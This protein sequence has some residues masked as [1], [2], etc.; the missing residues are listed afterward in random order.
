[1]TTCE[2]GVTLR[3]WELISSP[4]LRRENMVHLY[5]L[6]GAIFLFLEIASYIYFLGRRK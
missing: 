3:G 5:Y 2:V 4:S 1:M 6:M